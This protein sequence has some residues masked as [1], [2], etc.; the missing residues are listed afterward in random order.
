MVK[1]LPTIPVGT[2][3]SGTGTGCST[4]HGTLH[5]VGLAGS[6]HLAAL[7]PTT[8]IGAA[9]PPNVTAIPLVAVMKSPMAVLPSISSVGKAKFQ[10]LKPVIELS[11]SL[12]VLVLL[13]EM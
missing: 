3:A 1:A 6:A 8:P 4:V 13:G 11:L 5:P 9:V 10:Y 7:R 2:S 12:I